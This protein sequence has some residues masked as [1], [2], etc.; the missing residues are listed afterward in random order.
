MG[1]PHDDPSDVELSEE[2]E[3]G[4]T[5][6][7]PTPLPTDS[8]V[9]LK[10]S[11]EAPEEA[12][13]Y[14]AEAA[15]VNRDLSGF[16]DDAGDEASYG[17][18]AASETSRF[19]MREYQ[20]VA[21]ELTE[22]AN[23]NDSGEYT[24]PFQAEVADVGDL[25]DAAPSGE[26][27]GESLAMGEPE[28]I[29]AVEEAPATDSGFSMEEEPASEASFTVEEEPAPEPEPAPPSRPT[30]KM[31]APPAPAPAADEGRPGQ[32]AKNALDDIFARAAKLKKKPD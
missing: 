28:P 14:E 25:A 6:A 29:D 7:E 19:S 27:S 16:A 1:D 18:E 11:G 22:D 10:Y 2:V 9:D 15:P 17:F 4:S 31:K 32:I 20:E 3:S 12:D 21:E 26:D 13:A 24:S 5:P 23:L 30:T 8:A